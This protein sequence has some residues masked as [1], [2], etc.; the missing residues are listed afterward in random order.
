M[1]AKVVTW[2]INT[3]GNQETVDMLKAKGYEGWAFTVNMASKWVL[4]LKTRSVRWA[5]PTG[6]QLKSQV[7]L[8]RL[9]GEPDWEPW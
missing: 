6:H 2:D 1:G 5:L 9:D 4:R 3:A 7:P 8:F